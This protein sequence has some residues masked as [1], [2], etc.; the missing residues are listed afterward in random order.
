[1][2]MKNVSVDNNFVPRKNNPDNVNV[3]IVSTI[4]RKT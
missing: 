4:R 1:M 2:M 3:N